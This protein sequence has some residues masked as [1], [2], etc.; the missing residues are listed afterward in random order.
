VRHNIDI[1]HN[2]K[3]VFDNIF[4]TIMDVKG[5]TKDNLNL[6]ARHDMEVYCN[7]PELLVHTVRE[8]SMS[9]PKASYSL[10]A[11]A[12]K[13]LLEWISELHLPNGYASNLSRCVDMRELKM[14]WMKSYDCHGFI[15]RLLPIAL[16]EFLP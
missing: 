3:N 5:K 16:R 1:M 15:K 14:S 12:K 4:N 9:I 13:V 6:K 2:E 7:R 10:T 8:G 11:E